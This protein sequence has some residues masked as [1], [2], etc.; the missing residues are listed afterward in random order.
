[1]AGVTWLVSRHLQS[2]YYL[3]L[4]ARWAGRRWGCESVLH[5]VPPQGIA[6]PSDGVEVG[7]VGAAPSEFLMQ[8][9]G[10]WGGWGSGFALF[11]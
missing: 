7:G 10:G 5:R 9:L 1:M 11:K 8:L 2:R 3:V 4:N 6:T